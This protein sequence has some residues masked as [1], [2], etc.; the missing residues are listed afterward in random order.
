MITIENIY[1]TRNL[2]GKKI[3]IVR[4]YKKPIDN[5]P[6]WD[7]LSPSYGLLKTYLDLRKKGNWNQQT[8]DDIYVPQFLKEMKAYHQNDLNMLY[9]Q[10]KKQDLVLC[11]YCQHEEL[12]HRSIIAG[13]MQGA[14]IKVAG[15]DYSKYFAMYKNLQ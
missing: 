12:C 13:L 6:Q 9:T 2:N 4:S 5:M 15:K 14:G 10:A 11:C 8:F 1:K 3:A 7:A